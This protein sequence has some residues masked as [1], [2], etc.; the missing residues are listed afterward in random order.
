[1]TYLIAIITGVI[2]AAFGWAVA[3]VLTV[4]IGELLDVS[5]FEG[6]LGMLAFLGIG[7][8]GGFIGLVAG[9]WFILRRRGHVGLGAIAWRIP[10]VIVAVAGLAA[11]TMWYYNETRSN[12]S[13]SHGGTPRLNFEIRLPLGTVP[14]TPL[15]RIRIELNTERNR[16]SGLVF[17]RAGRREDDRLIIAGSVEL[18]YRS[19]WRLLELIMA[20]DEPV[21]I[22]DLKLASRPPHMKGFGPW[23]RVDF[24][25]TGDE[26]PKPATDADAY[27][28]R[29]RVVYPGAE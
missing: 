14:A 5:N 20:P 6:R 8:I 15:S 9:V 23:R 11:G 18:H 2:G 28:I 16:I 22:F 21:R 25:A 24:I 26:Q 17:D 19:S 7:P 3:A 27:D 10:V 29:T 1:M 13:T 12:L 4:L